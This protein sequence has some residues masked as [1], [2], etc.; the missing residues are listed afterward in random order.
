MQKDHLVGG[1]EQIKDMAIFGASPRWGRP[2]AHNWF[3]KP[4]GAGRCALGDAVNDYTHTHEC[5]SDLHDQDARTFM[6]FV[7]YAEGAA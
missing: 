3:G 6:L 5:L 1:A 2:N 4:P 7:A